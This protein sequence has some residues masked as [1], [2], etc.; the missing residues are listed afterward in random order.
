MPTLAGF[1]RPQDPINA[2]APGRKITTD[3]GKAVTGT[4]L[5]FSS[6]NTTGLTCFADVSSTALSGGTQLPFSMYAI[7]GQRTEFL[8]DDQFIVYAAV[9]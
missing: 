8:E 5:N 4:N 3:T 7:G 2:D 1:T 9:M 6:S